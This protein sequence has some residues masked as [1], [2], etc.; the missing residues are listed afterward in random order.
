MKYRGI[1]AH[2]EYANQTLDWFSTDNEKTFNWH[3]RKDFGKVDESGWLDR[4][5]EYSFNSLGFR[6]EEFDDS[7]KAVVFLGGSEVIGTGVPIKDAFPELV[8]A[9]LKM[10]CYNLAQ[11]GAANDTTYRMASYWLPKLKPKL[12]VMLSPPPFRIE[13]I[14]AFQD[15]PITF[16]VPQFYAK[17]PFFKT[18]LSCDDNS[19][20]NEEKNKLAVQHICKANKI[21]LI[22]S[23][24][25]DFEQLDYARDFIHKGMQSHAVFAQQILAKI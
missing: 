8:A 11:S 19:L 18:W 17:D 16:Y 22:S 9:K 1:S 21:K 12:V 6:S 23:E 4:K 2:V 7:K 5:V 25:T 13:V 20:L 10:K 24:D 15:Q 3:L 14:D